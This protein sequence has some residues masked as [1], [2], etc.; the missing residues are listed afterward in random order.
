[1]LRPAPWV[2]LLILSLPS[3]QAAAADDPLW[4]KAVEAASRANEWSPGEMRL[5]IEMADEHGTVL[6]TWDNRYR[7]S[8]G[9]D[10]RVKTE[11][12]S[13]F[14]NR[15]DET[16]KERE[17]QARRDRDARTNGASPV[18]RFGDDPFDPSV[19]GSLEIRRLDGTR[20]IAGM[21]C[22]GFA[23][24]LS[25]HAD[26]SVAGTAWLDAATGLP[27]EVVSSPKPLPRGARELA[28]VVR[29]TNGLVSEVLVEGNGSLL[30]LKRRFSSVVTLSGWFRKPGG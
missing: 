3:A 19:Q 29:Y 12:V 21:A 6:D 24:L 5:A 28:T 9:A 7:F 16:Q 17:A 15:K 27:V 25:K 1:M 14:H 10:G 23:F 18:S 20:A 13:A 30:F 4:A 8:I 22:V 26:A 2:L 11:V